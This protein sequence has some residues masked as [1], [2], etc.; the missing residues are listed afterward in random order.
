M[1]NLY[2]NFVRI[3]EICKLFTEDLVNDKRNYQGLLTRI[4]DLPDSMALL[5]KNSILKPCEGLILHDCEKIIESKREKSR[6]TEY[7][8]S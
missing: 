8:C 4:T 6:K 5:L 2:T 1:H 7:L 3:L